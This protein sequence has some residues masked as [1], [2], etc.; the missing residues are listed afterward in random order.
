VGDISNLA[1]LDFVQQYY[2]IPRKLTDGKDKITVRFSGGKV[3]VYGLR[4]LTENHIPPIVTA[5]AEPKE[6]DVFIT[7]GQGS[8]YISSANGNLQNSDVAVYNTNGQQILHTRLNHSQVNLPLSLARGVY[9]VSINNDS[10]SE[11]RK[12]GVY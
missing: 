5:I 4:L 3:S 11:T 10:Y 1:P 8:L 2:K 6:G 7:Y 9:I 12:I